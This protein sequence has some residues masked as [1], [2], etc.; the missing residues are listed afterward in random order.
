MGK[1]PVLLQ[2]E[3]ESAEIRG[4]KVHLHV[5]KS[6]GTKETLQADHI[7][8]ATGYKTDVRRL[9]FLDP[10]LLA[11]IRTVENAPILSLNY[12]SSI[13]G[14]HFIGLASANSFGPV[15]RFAFGAIHPSPPSDGLSVESAWQPVEHCF[16]RVIGGSKYTQNQVLCVIKDLLAHTIDLV[17]ILFDAEC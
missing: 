1:F 16:N 13:P 3:L 2:R 11:R 15:A 17:T 8:A 12:E 4:G 7:I 14:L 5:A 10:R 9:S 6:D